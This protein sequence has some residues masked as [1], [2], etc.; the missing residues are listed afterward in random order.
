MV[1]IVT[2]CY[3]GSKVDLFPEPSQTEI[4]ILFEDPSPS[5]GKILTTL[6]LP[7][8]QYT[9][10]TLATTS[11]YTLGVTSFIFIN[12]EVTPMGRVVGV[13]LNEDSNQSLRALTRSIS[14]VVRVHVL[15][16]PVGRP[17]TL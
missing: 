3:R 16:T 4:F 17:S 7:P 15:V 5:G 14:E 6:E 1:A 11:K 9:N 13:T 10:S 2:K 8:T 12:L